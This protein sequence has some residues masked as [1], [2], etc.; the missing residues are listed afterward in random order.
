[1]SATITRRAFFGGAA[2]TAL[3][4]LAPASA[5]AEESMAGRWDTEG[6]SGIWIDSIGRRVE[7]TG[8][9]RIVPAGAY[10]EAILTS[11]APDKVISRANDSEELAI[12]RDGKELPL[13][14]GLYSAAYP[15]DVEVIRDLSPDIIIDMG[16]L[17]PTAQ[18][19][20]DYLQEET[21]VP[22]VFIHSDY[23]RLAQAYRALACLLSS[24]K[25]IELAEYALDVAQYVRAG[26]SCI[27][28]NDRYSV[29][30]GSGDEGD[31]VH[32][33]DSIIG[34]T[35]KEVGISSQSPNMA[36]ERTKTIS[37][38]EIF[39]WNPNIIVMGN[40]KAFSKTQ[41]VDPYSPIA[42]QSTNAGFYERVR[43]AQITRQLWLDDLSLLSKQLVGA[44]YLGNLLYPDVFQYNFA[45]V[46]S[47]YYSLFFG[48]EPEASSARGRSV[49]QDELPTSEDIAG[50]DEQREQ[51]LKDEAEK[52]LAYQDKWLKKQEELAKKYEQ[53]MSE[54]EGAE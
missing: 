37:N 4:L 31:V 11:V 23:L 9:E 25:A 51:K 12:I 1:M 49:L 16:E 17:K 41:N 40:K 34:E 44:L 46:C 6:A 53:Q 26:A 5:M 2:F 8:L 22:V 36:D 52:F 28:E 3:Q 42:W 20:L 33:G 39:E 13:T 10:A 54:Q 50:Q 35:I 21:G 47:E 29:Y 19:D 38:D 7:I 43:P 48:Y 32:A 18:T 14:G 30:L 15:I 45:N 24:E 27:K